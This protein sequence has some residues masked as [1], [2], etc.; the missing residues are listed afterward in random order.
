MK[1]EFNVPDIT[2]KHLV[3]AG[4][5]VGVLMAGF[6]IY[7]VTL[8]NPV[9]AANCANWHEALTAAADGK[10]ETRDMY[11]SSSYS[12]LQKGDINQLQM[13]FQALYEQAKPHAMRCTEAGF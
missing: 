9:N 7:K 2:K 8:G 6:G 11:E 1:I 5:S 4:A 3:I 12:Y 13:D 10:R